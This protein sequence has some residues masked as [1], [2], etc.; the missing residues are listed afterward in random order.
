MSLQTLFLENISPKQTVL[1]NSFWLFLGQGL[2]KLF[3]FFLVMAAARILGPTDFGAFNYLFSIVSLFFIFS[4]W[5]VSSLVIRDYQNETVDKDKYV[6]SAFG[7]K[8]ILAA[9][10]FLAVLISLLFFQ[11]PVFKAGLILLAIFLVISNLRDFIIY[12][13]RAFQKME[14]EFWLVL[15]ENFSLLIIGVTLLL[16]YKNIVSL[17]LAYVFSI[18]ISLSLAFI[19]F[20]RY[21]SYL[22]PEWGR[23]EIKS[24]LANGAPIMFYGL[25]SFIFFATDQIILGK[26][27]GT[28]EVG[29]YSIVTKIIILANMVPG[30]LMTALFP[31]LASQAANVKK[32]MMI[33]K[34]VSLGLVVLGVAAAAFGAVS[35]PIIPLIVGSQYAPSVGLFRFFVWIIVFMF[36]LNLFDYIL[37]TYN[38]QWLNFWFTAAC[39]I[40]NIVLNFLLI[41]FY[42]MIG[43]AVASMI[44]QFLNFVIS[45]YLSRRVLNNALKSSPSNVQA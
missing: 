32:V 3:K 4:D 42:G 23:K 41:P 33:F 15:A 40:V 22:K 44:A 12:I 34:K 5:G 28:T 18:V 43:A 37:F 36:P 19:L 8:I 2:S 13:F 38:K 35:A 30:L 11:S 9:A 20:K 16:I 24:F 14:K 29:Y 45:W 21:F 7:L 39:A 6:R 27:R 31:Y 1:K 25:L 10:A 17:S 26:L